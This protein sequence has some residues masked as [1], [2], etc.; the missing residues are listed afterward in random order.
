ML[1]L[2]EDTKFYVFQDFGLER[3]DDLIDFLIY[4]NIRLVRLEFLVSLLHQKRLWP[5]RQEAE[6]AGGHRM[7]S[8]NIGNFPMDP[9]PR[10]LTTS[11]KQLLVTRRLTTSN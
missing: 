3:P 5:R 2:V 9:L 1:A 8:P 4:A 11:N 7:G 6:K 10:H